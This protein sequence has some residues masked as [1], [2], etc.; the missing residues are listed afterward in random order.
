LIAPETALI[1]CRFVFDGAAIFLWGTSAYLATAVPS[2]LARDIAARLVRYQVGASLLV[3][4]AALAMLPVET[5]LIGDGWTSWR[6][7]ATVSDVVFGTTVGLAWR[8]QIAGAASLSLAMLALGPRQIVFAVFSA[9]LL[10]SLA[11][12]GHAAMNDGWTDILHRA[13]HVLHL[14]SGGAWLGSLVPVLMILRRLRDPEARTAL[15]RFSRLGH[16]A[17]ALVILTGFANMYLILGG[18][19]TDWAFLYQRLLSI[20][21]VLV[22]V[23]TALA[24]V[25]RYVLVPRMARGDGS[26]RMRLARSTVTEVLLGA[27]AVAIVAWLGV[28]EPD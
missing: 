27:G 14:L 26:A 4:L 16:F 5:A 21:V 15:T 25:N 7:P 1:F 19:A 23:M 11:I 6:D 2:R 18:P 13:N 20:K 28:L 8:V 24:L 3:L 22:L 9:A 17:V 12:T 10:A